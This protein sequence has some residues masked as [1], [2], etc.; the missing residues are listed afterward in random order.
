[1]L[2]S[3]LPQGGSTVHTEVATFVTSI[4][5]V[6]QS[7]SELGQTQSELGRRSSEPDPLYASIDEAR[8]SGWE[9]FEI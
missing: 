8:M 3:A 9:N 5:N 2:F 7:S 4:G 6:G 1:M